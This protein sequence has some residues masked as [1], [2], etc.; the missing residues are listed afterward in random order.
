LKYEQKFDKEGRPVRG[1]VLQTV[2]NCEIVLQKDSRFA[3]KI[4]FDVFSKQIRLFGGVPWDISNKER[5]WVDNDDKQ[6][7]ALVQDEYALNYRANLVDSV[8]NIAHLNKIHPVQEFLNSL[9]WDGQAHIRKLLPDFLGAE[10][11]EYNYECLKL[12]M[13]GAIK[14]VFEAGC[15]C[16]NM[17]I[18]QGGQGIGK[19]TFFRRLAMRD[20]WFNDSLMTLE[21]ERAVQLLLGS[22]IIELGEL[23]AIARTAGG[24][25]SVKQFLSVKQDKIRLPYNKSTEDIPRQCVFGGTTNQAVFLDDLTGNRRF[26]IIP[27]GIN[28]ATKSLFDNDTTDKEFRQAWAEA[29]HIWK[30]ERPPLVLPKSCIAQAEE[31]QKASNNDDGMRGLIEK[32][33]EDKDRVCVLQIWREA[34]E[35]LGRPGRKDS[36]RIVQIVLDLGW[37]RAKKPISSGKYKAQKAFVGNQDFKALSESEQKEAPFNKQC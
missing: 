36:D 17:L 18:L 10:D 26:L 3:N 12:F 2:K 35:E 30:T 23:K 25:E 13:L 14:R 28:Q 22:W 19:S 34:L 4:R 31:L 27:V 5:P 1:K 29:L 37:K 8:Q 11:T 21:G 20:E 33:L 7:F 32:F 9:E 15:K 6:L 16:D 24:V